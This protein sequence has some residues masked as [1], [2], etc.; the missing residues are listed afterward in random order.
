M[1]IAVIALSLVFPSALCFTGTVLHGS[2]TNELK[3]N[4]KQQS[5][6][7][8]LSRVHKLS[9]KE[10]D[11]SRSRRDLIFST[12]ASTLLAGVIPILTQVESV[13]A[14]IPGFDTRG[15]R[16]AGL[17]PIA[18]GR[19]LSLCSNENCVSTSEG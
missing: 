10:S 13:S 3:Y 14:Q 12:A 4:S 8:Q 1:R 9:M 5:F 2:C 15:E 17:G 11:N 6:R 19:F 16:P 18:G 7:Q